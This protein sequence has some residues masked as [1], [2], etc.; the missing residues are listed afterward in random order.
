MVS[1]FGVGVD[2]A[3][4]GRDEPSVDR[5]AGVGGVQVDQV[6]GGGD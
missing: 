5:G 3:E 6:E 2:E 1:F 4:E